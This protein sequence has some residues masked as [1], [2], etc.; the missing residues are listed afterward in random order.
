MDVREI[1]DYF[2]GS[3][4]VYKRINVNHSAVVN[5]HRLNNMPDSAAC[6]FYEHAIK[7][8]DTVLAKI[9]EPRLPMTGWYGTQQLVRDLGGEQKVRK[10]IRKPEYQFNNWYRHCTVPEK[11]YVQI[12]RVCEQR[13]M[14]EALHF[15]LALKNTP[16]KM[17]ENMVRG[18]VPP[19]PMERIKSVF[20]PRLRESRDGFLLLDGRKTDWKRA[21]IAANRILI[22]ESKPPIP[23]PGVCP[24]N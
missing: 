20:G 18:I 3:S 12:L 16:K 2:G 14:A 6:L 11:F 7:S 22:L 9:I 21:A 8:G 24:K 10:I 17:D 19:S 1:I 13:K 23:Y 15:L 5:W 4:S